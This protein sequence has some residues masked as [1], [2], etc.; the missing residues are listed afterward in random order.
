MLK[1]IID[2]GNYNYQFC[3][4]IDSPF[5]LRDADANECYIKS[6]LV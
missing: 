3:E 1:S 6:C 2:Y 4:N 5:L